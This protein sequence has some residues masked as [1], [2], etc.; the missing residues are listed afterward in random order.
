MKFF[1][2]K[3]RRLQAAGLAA[4]L[5]VGTMAAPAGRMTAV[6]ETTLAASKKIELSKST[7]TLKAG[8][9]KKIRLKNVNKKKRTKIKWM[10]SDK[11]IISI[12]VNKKKRSA[13]T[14]KAKKKGTATVTAQLSGKKY[15]CKVTVKS[16]DRTPAPTPQ[17]IYVEVT[18]A[19]EA[20]AAP[21]DTPA[22]A[23][24]GNLTFQ[25]DVN[26]E[27]LNASY[28]AELSENPDEVMVSSKEIEE[29]NQDILA[30][31]ETHTNDLLNISETFPATAKKEELAAALISEVKEGRSNGKTLY[32]DGVE[33]E[34]KDAFFEPMYNNILNAETEEQEKVKYALCTK[35]VEIKMA[36]VDGLVGF[37][38]KDTDDEFVDSRLNVNE[39]FIVE[40]VTADGAYYWGRTVNCSGWVRA[41]H[42]AVCGSKDEWKSM[43]TGKGEDILVVTTDQLTMAPS[44]YSKELSRIELHLG[45]VLPLVPKNEIPESIDG[46]GTWYNH[47]V[48]V[49]TR[50]ENGVLVKSMAL[51]SMNREVSIGYLPFTKRN[52]LNT[53]FS[54]LGDRYGWGGMMDLMDCSLYVRD[55]YRCFGFELP[56]NTT[57]QIETPTENVD[58]SGMTDE[59]KRK[60]IDALDPGTLLMFSG[61]ITM[62]IGSTGGK[63][64]V[65]SDMGSVAETESVSSDAAV[66]SIFC[67]SVNSLDVRRKNGN[68]WL[69]EMKMAVRPWKHPGQ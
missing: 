52:V 33:V 55:I 13:V 26:A 34:D 11:K 20:T 56:R 41:D 48:Y 21:V 46:R 65:I 32:L 4:V 19:P 64:Y 61:H 66:K 31:S 36:P 14:V 2:G 49:P 30:K 51:V 69:S 22:L 8:T 57:W 53:A 17:I 1:S 23:P 50:D 25:S 44:A 7:L 60:T 43:W 3:A 12:T 38:A 9:S 47:V 42:M 16:A 5:T 59:E 62:Y 27:M 29:V 24:Q 6:Q 39:P 37:S 67:V 15:K 63:Q 45:T 54:C 35:S 68:T 40:A 18:P 58:L 28:W 10:T